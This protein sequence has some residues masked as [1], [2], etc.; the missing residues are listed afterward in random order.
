VSSL[1]SHPVFHFIF[2]SYLF[3]VGEGEV[4]RR[5]HLA[6]VRSLLP[7]THA[8]PELETQ[9]W[10]QGT[11]SSPC[12]FPSPPSERPGV[13]VEGPSMERPQALSIGSF[14]LEGAQQPEIQNVLFQLDLPAM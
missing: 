7:P 3:S 4:H 6:G 9:A 11:S 10:W 8:V 2:K 12:P 13:G 1:A 5:R 14:E